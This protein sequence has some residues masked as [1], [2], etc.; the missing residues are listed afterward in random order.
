M[1]EMGGTSPRQ[2]STQRR[3]DYRSMVHL[4]SPNAFVLNVN[5][6]F[7]HFSVR[8]GKI[9]WNTQQEGVHK[10][11]N[12]PTYLTSLYALFYLQRSMPNTSPNL[13][14]CPAALFMYSTWLLLGVTRTA[15]A[16]PR[17][18]INILKDFHDF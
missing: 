1:Q 11:H 9:S 12:I 5:F 7:E 17:E 14:T 13:Q 6:T 8:T 2:A 18:V 3:R 10:M 4:A 15:H 16:L